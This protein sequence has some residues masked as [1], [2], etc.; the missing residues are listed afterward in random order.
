MPLPVGGSFADGFSGFEARLED[1]DGDGVQIGAVGN[2]SAQ[3]PE[4]PRDSRPFAFLVAA[5]ASPVEQ[6]R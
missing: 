4:S 3:R 6:R 2:T 5:G 1:T